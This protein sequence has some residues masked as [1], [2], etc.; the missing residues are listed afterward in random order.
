MVDHAILII[1]TELEI[2]LLGL[3]FRVLNGSQCI[4]L[5]SFL[6]MERII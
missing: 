2:V 1:K 3:Q 6:G 5:A 4:I